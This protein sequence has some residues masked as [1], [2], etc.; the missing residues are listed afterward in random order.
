MEES[1]DMDEDITEL[2]GHFVDRAA[3]GYHNEKQSSLSAMAILF[4]YMVWKCERVSVDPDLK[5]AGR[6]AVGKIERH[7]EWILEKFTSLVTLA[8]ITPVTSV[9]STVSYFF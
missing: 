4:R 8:D 6:A 1:E 3:Y 9:K 5:E 7:R 2:V